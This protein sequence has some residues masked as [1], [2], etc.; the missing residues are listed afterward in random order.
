MLSETQKQILKL[1]QEAKTIREIADIL[2]ISQHCVKAILKVVLRHLE[3][4]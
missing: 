4:R 2:Q 1:Y 3:I